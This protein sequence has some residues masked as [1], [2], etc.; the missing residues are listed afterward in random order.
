MDEPPRGMFVSPAGLPRFVSIP[1]PSQVEAGAGADLQD[2]QRQSSP[3]CDL[4]ESSEQCRAVTNL[5]RLASSPDQPANLGPTL[6]QSGPKQ[7][8]R[9]RGIAV[10]TNGRVVGREK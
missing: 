6:C 10:A 2:A 9:R 5:V 3:M 1:V 7:G 4:E 8:P